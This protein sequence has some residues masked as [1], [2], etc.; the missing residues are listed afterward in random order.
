MPTLLAKILH[1]TL[2]AL[3]LSVTMLAASA[4]ILSAAG[5]AQASS[6][7]NA[8]GPASPTGSRAVNAGTGHVPR[9]SHNDTPHGM[10]PA[11]RGKRGT[12]GNAT[13]Y[14]GDGNF[15]YYMYNQQNGAV[16]TDAR[17]Y[18]IYWGDWST[19][20]HGVMT[21]LY[22]FYRGIGGSTW[23][24]VMTQYQQGCTPQTWTC[25]GAHA[26]NPTAPFKSWS[27]D[28]TTVPSTPTAAQI[29]AEAL[30]M[31]IN[32]FHDYSY[33]AQYVVALPPGHGDTQF[34]NGTACA[35]H[36]YAY[37]P[38]STSWITVTAMPY[39][40]DKPSC[41]M[42]LANT[43]SAGYLDGVT[44]VAGH[45][46]AETITDP[47]LNAWYDAVTKPLWENGDKCAGYAANMTFPTGTFAMQP[48][49]S[50]YYR[51]YHGWGCVYSA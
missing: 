43:G 31:A 34:T 4:V 41:Y 42:N 28:T 30:R 35:W 9:P 25:T 37:I 6:Q 38:G 13:P 32:V 22:N 20:T 19:D 29:N 8:N 23:G 26:G 16:Q 12:T 50:N 10:L 44:I 47:G 15:P 18:L 40:P 49:W 33:N 3:M 5:T 48:T 21:R 46:Y 14:G 7:S 36:D 17:V 39:Q 11:L 27:K 1:R 45:E 2:K 51:Y 24:N